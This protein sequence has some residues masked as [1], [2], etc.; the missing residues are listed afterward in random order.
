MMKLDMFMTHYNP[1]L[2]IVIA[3][4]A[5]GYGKGAV[6]LHVIAVGSEKM[7]THES[8]SLTPAAKNSIQI[9]REELITVY[10]VKKFNKWVY[11]RHFTLLTEKNK[12]SLDLRMIQHIQRIIF[13]VGQ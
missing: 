8:R 10:A 6:I 9:K 12:K 5:A 2:P 3:A 7:A 11:S 1:D 4:D 13:S